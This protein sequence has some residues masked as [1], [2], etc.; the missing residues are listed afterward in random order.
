M[1]IKRHPRKLRGMPSATNGRREPKYI[2]HWIP[3]KYAWKVQ[4]LTGEVKRFR[5][6]ILGFVEVSWTDFGETTTDEG[7]KIWYCG[8][9]SKH[10][11][12]VAVIWRREVVGSII[13]CTP[14]SSRLITIQISARPHN[15]TVIQVYAPTSDHEDKEV[16]EF[17]Q[18]LNSIIEKTPRKGYTFSSSQSGHWCILTLARDSRKIWHWR[19]K[20]QDGNS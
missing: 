14:F 17:L 5:W 4:E 9:D 20:W 19:N 2:K 13:S 8:E 18:Q 15:I 11:Y 16:K 1:P 7:Y 12:G 3:A 10:Q 6:D